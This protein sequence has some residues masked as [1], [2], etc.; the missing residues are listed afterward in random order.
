MFYLD[1]ILIICIFVPP[2]KKWKV[3]NWCLLVKKLTGHLFVTYQRKNWLPTHI[4]THKAHSSQLTQKVG[5][6]VKIWSVSYLSPCR[7]SHMVITYFHARGRA[8]LMIRIVDGD[9]AKVNTPY[10]K[11][12]CTDVVHAF[13]VISQNK[14]SRHHDTHQY[15]QWRTSVCYLRRKPDRQ[16]LFRSTGRQ[17]PCLIAHCDIE[18][19][20]YLAGKC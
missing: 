11:F 7:E 14:Y 5:G 3:T 18:G 1:Q 12:Q 6:H 4:F 13:I 16:K 20:F 19:G 15:W 17:H 2:P 9:G 10:F 8:K